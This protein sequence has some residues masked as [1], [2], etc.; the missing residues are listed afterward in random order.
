[1]QVVRQVVHSVVLLYPFVCA[2]C[3]EHSANGNTTSLTRFSVVNSRRGRR[4][5]FRHTL[6]R[7]MRRGG[8]HPV[9]VSAVV[10]HKRVELA[11]EVYDRATLD[12][13][14]QALGVVGRELLPIGSNS[15]SVQ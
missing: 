6:I 10:G 2:P 9:V 4:N 11:P 3:W 15:T 12:E 8:V 14:R 5:D 13:K 7:K 1:M